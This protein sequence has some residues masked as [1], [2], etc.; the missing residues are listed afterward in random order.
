M[1]LTLTLAGPPLALLALAIASACGTGGG[2]GRGGG[3]AAPPATGPFEVA[4]ARA[5]SAH[6]VEV[7]FTH[8]VDGAAASDVTAFAVAGLPLYAALPDPLDTRAVRLET[9][10]QAG[11]GAAYEVVVGPALRS[12][13][14]LALAGRDRATFAG[15]GAAPA[16]FET[17][18]PP[19]TSLADLVARGW[20][21]ED[22]PRATNAGPSAWTV[23]AAAGAIVQTSNIYGGDAGDRID[24]SKPGTVLVWRG[25]GAAPPLAADHLVEATVETP[26]DDG[27]GLVVRYRDP[28]NHYRFDWLAQGAR[29]QIVKVAGGV[30]TRLA[31]DLEPYAPG[32]RYRLRFQARGTRLCA[33]VDGALVLSADDPDLASGGAGLY[34]WGSA[35]ARFDDVRV[36]PL[37]PRAPRPAPAPLA[38]DGRPRETAP[39]IPHGTAAGDP[40]PDRATLW[41]RTSAAAD[42]A[43][44]VSTAPDLAGATRSA[45]PRTAA[46]TAFAAQV[47]I[48]GLRP[49]TRYFYRAV[50][51]DP[52][53]PHERNASPI[54]TFATAPDPTAAADLVFAYGA[55]ISQ[56]SR[57]DY[58]IFA[59]IAA[60]DPAFF[61][62]LGDFP[63][64]DATPAA[65]TARGYEEKHGEVRCAGEIR[66]FLA[67]VPIVAVWDD[68]EVA[69]DWNGAT[70]AARVALGTAAWRAFFPARPDP[71]IAPGARPI[72][73]ALRLGRD[74]EVFVLDTRS[75]R[76]ANSAPDGPTK[77]MLGATQRAWL[78]SRLLASTARFKLIA[79]SVPLR[80]GTTGTDHWEGFA[81]E[82]AALFDF[83]HRNHIAGVAFLSGDQHWA[84]VNRHPEGFSEVQACPVAAFLRQPP[85][86]LDPHVVFLEKTQSY[87]LVR[88][89]MIA[90]APR[91]DIEVR[92]P[93]GRLLFTET[94]R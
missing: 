36:Q 63:Y 85:A 91:V 2:R 70:S 37:A 60:H 75:A 78:E 92:A 28:A 20:A 46:A 7:R 14:G 67:S 26:D 23:D 80:Y 71:S 3:T 51:S 93:N 35:G 1:R 18:D 42:V 76:S 86:I 30:A 61:L 58:G 48:A 56:S 27:L 57:A 90:A 21:V 11:G 83:I 45:A 55:D 10:E 81:T 66:R 65:T 29:R 53:E 44:L 40:A 33:F 89:F 72:Y 12:A 8:A 59:E 68:H 22:D 17:L 32:T 82:R 25:G 73:R 64:C 52:A 16:A 84:S 49:A 31:F 69:N 54:A 39:L 88:T 15:G 13:A 50:A 38:A 5:L 6:E 9:G 19:V 79:T 47:E 34:V 4:S 94:I 77:T 41:A 43:F 87:G 74:L 24:P 62:S